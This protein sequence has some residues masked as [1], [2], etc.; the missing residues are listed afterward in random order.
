M[1][2][3]WSKG[4]EP[5]RRAAYICELSTWGVPADIHR[6]RRTEASKT[7]GGLPYWDE[8]PKEFVLTVPEL[9]LMRVKVFRN[10]NLEVDN[11][12]GQAVVPV[13]FLRQ[14]FRTLRLLDK[15]CQDLE[16]PQ[17]L[18]HIALVAPETDL[19]DGH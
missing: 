5:A 1:G 11:F 3:G 10:M 14:G 16:G 13:H 2:S 4:D 7:V 12:F 18:W 15:A 6:K 8:A 17:L 19:V 9:A